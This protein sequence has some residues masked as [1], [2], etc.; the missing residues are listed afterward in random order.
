MELSF[1]CP[2]LTCFVSTAAAAL[3]RLPRVSAYP[4]FLRARGGAW[5]YALR[6]GAGATTIRLWPG[7]NATRHNCRRRFCTRSGTNW[8]KWKR[9][10]HA[11]TG[12][13]RDVAGPHGPPGALEG[14]GSAGGTSN[15][16]FAIWPTGAILNRIWAILGVQRAA[17]AG[18]FD[19]AD[20]PPRTL[21][22]SGTPF[23]CYKPRVSP[24]HLLLCCRH[25]MA[26][27]VRF[28][29]Q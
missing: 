24:P 23:P 7:P 21:L 22:G 20:P 9:A 12:G 25:P 17:T 6:K 15:S 18:L 27:M 16:A 26:G 4:V 11:V 1:C 2:S 13:P 29:S 3:C 10:F 8:L 19:S 14:P 5:V 28:V